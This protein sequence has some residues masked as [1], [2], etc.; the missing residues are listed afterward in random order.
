MALGSPLLVM[1]VLLTAALAHC[2]EIRV[3]PDCAI[4]DLRTAVEVAAPGDTVV[5]APGTYEAPVRVD[6]DLT[7]VGEGGVPCWWPPT[8]RRSRSRTRRSGSGG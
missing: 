7:I 5:L 8:P 4:K 1:G 6:K 2:A 3:C